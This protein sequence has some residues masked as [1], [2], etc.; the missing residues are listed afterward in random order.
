MPAR[1]IFLIVSSTLFL[2]PILS[3]LSGK[4]T[5]ASSLPSR[6][7]VTSNHPRADTVDQ[8]RQDNDHAHQRLLPVGADLREHEAVA[9][10]LEQHTADAGT[11]RTADAAGQIGAADHGG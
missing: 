6:N 8:H 11:E 7:D 10:P 1:R 5:G 4:R 2:A 9:D 3:R